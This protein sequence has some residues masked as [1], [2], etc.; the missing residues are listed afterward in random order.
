MS[1]IV[2]ILNRNAKYGKYIS[3]ERIFKV[4]DEEARKLTMYKKP[5]VIAVVGKTKCGVYEITG[6]TFI[7]KNSN[8]ELYNELFAEI[9]N[10]KIESL[11]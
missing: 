2:D 7:H 9:R 4:G 3:V 10:S 6:K 1:N 11:F 5:N 8:E